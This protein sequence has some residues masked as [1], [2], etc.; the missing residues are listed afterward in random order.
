M[1]LLR[2]IS[3]A[4]KSMVSLLT[5]SLVTSLRIYSTGFWKRFCRYL[6]LLVISIFYPHSPKS[7]IFIGTQF[8]LTLLSLNNLVSLFLCSTLILSGRSEASGIDYMIG[9]PL[10]VDKL[11]LEH[12]FDRTAFLSIWLKEM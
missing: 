3:R 11:R 5:D 7:Y 1:R 6:I 2:P 9:E 10:M 8:S 4:V 12:I